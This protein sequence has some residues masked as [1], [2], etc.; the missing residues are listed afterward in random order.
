MTSDFFYEYDNL[1]P[2]AQLP[3]TTS[4][5]ENAG[6]RITLPYQDVTEKP[7]WTVGSPECRSSILT[8]HSPDDL[9]TSFD[10]D[11]Q[12]ILKFGTAM[13]IL[14]T[15]KLTQ[16]DDSLRSLSPSERQCYFEGERRLK[17]FKVYTQSNCEFE[18]LSMRSVQR[19]LNVVS[20]PSN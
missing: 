12:T 2:N 8:I 15:P 18:C 7:S 6:L 4:S 9:P 11:Y 1:K 19:T 5:T 3:M 20:S 10:D 17:F 16:T 13:E 14:I